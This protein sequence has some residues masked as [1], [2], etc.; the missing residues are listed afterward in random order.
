MYN[1]NPHYTFKEFNVYLNPEVGQFN[2]NCDPNLSDF[3]EIVIK[4]YKSDYPY[5]YVE[6]LDEPNE[7]LVVKWPHVD[8]DSE[9]SKI[10]VE[11]YFH[12][13]ITEIDKQGQ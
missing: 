1:N 9:T 12:K 7:M 10:K 6:I 2:I 5:C 3:N 13:I 8:I 11:S 4:T